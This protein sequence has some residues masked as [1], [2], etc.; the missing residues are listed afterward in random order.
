[1]KKSLFIP[2]IAILVVGIAFY[3][4]MQYQKIGSS[5]NGTSNLRRGQQQGNG[6]NR[7]GGNFTSGEIVSKDDQSLTVKMPNGSTKIVFYSAK[8][9]LAKQTP[10]TVDDLKA[11]ETVMIG[12]TTNPD[13]SVT[14]NNI[15]IGAIIDRGRPDALSTSG[16]PANPSSQNPEGGNFT[17][18]QPLIQ[19][20]IPPVPSVTV[21]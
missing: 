16:Q 7:I 2:I 4:G 17:Q 6:S 18:T 11:G 3:G 20:T 21:N 9:T 12:S 5:S 1:M 19:G 13:G 10:A 8:T 14:A 15:Q